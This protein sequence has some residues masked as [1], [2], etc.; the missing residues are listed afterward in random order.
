MTKAEKRNDK[1]LDFGAGCIVVWGM[2]LMVLGGLYAITLFFSLLWHAR[3]TANLTQ[4]DRRIAIYQVEY[5][6]ASEL[7]SAL[8]EGTAQFRMNQ[9]SPV[10]AVAAG[11]IEV[12]GKLVDVKTQKLNLQRDIIDRCNG[13]WALTVL[14]FDDKTCD[15]YRGL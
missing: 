4:I 3:D 13:P 15:H 5:D 7:L 2:I 10:N 9:D 8:R 1:L 11:Q 14:M 6:K 12:A